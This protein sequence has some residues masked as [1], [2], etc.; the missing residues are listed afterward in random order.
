MRI[1]IQCVGGVGGGVCGCSL[2]TSSTVSGGFCNIACNVGTTV[3][4]GSQNVATGNYSSILGGISNKTCTCTCAMIVGSNICAN[5][6]CSTFVNNLSIMN[7]PTSGA[8]LPAGS[9]Y[10]VGNSL[11]ITT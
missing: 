11:C 7:I 6:S 1:L 5:R 8:G 3:A 2:N 10:R 4:G 9:V